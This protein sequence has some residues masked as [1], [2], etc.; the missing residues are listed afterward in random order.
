[1]VNIL[2][3][4]TLSNLEIRGVSFLNLA[5]TQRKKK[6]KKTTMKYQENIYKFQQKVY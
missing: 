4:I 3:I 5:K 6:R 1:M 2:T